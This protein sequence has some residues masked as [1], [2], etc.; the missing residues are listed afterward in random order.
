MHSFERS[1]IREATLAEYPRLLKDIRRLHPDRGLLT[2]ICDH[3]IDLGFLGK[4]VH[5][6]AR[7]RPLGHDNQVH[8]HRNS[9]TFL[10]QDMQELSDSPIDNMQHMPRHP[11]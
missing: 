6:H 4:D 2:L 7:D 1:K 11:S 3:L 5:D 8:G 10:L 9:D